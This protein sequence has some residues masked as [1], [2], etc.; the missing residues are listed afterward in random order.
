MTD[1]SGNGKPPELL[2][3]ITH[4]LQFEDGSRIHMTGEA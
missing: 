1:P 4:P 3:I 2:T